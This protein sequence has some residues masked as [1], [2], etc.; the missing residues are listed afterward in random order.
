MRKNSLWPFSFDDELSDS[1]SEKE[2]D[3]E[4]EEDNAEDEED[5][6]SE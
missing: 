4:E 2:S 6:L 5:M 3:T 1:S